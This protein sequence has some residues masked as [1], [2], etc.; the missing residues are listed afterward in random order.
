M[1]KQSG[2]IVHH[3]ESPPGIDDPAFRPL[4]EKT[5]D[6]EYRSAGHL[7]QFFSRERY[8]NNARTM[9]LCR[10]KRTHYCACHSQCYLLRRKFPKALLHLMQLVV[11]ELEGAMP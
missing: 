9:H 1:F 3:D 10:C 4:G 8:V 6:C 2:R 7:G 11:Q 5:A